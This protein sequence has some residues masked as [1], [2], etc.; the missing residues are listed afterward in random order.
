M[1]PYAFPGQHEHSSTAVSRYPWMSILLSLLVLYSSLLPSTPI[2]SL[3]NIFSTVKHFIPKCAW[4][5]LFIIQHFFEIFPYFWSL[6]YLPFT[7][8]IFWGSFVH[9]RN[10][11]CIIMCSTVLSCVYISPLQVTSLWELLPPWGQWSIW[12]ILMSS[13]NTVRLETKC[14][15]KCVLCQQ[16]IISEDGCQ[17][18]ATL[19]YKLPYLV[20]KRQVFKIIWCTPFL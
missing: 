15:H 4:I 13:A 10:V 2:H 1:F 19:W 3:H 9:C 6:L 17:G 16:C 8:L 7:G 20:A 12:L 14:L 5:S 11:H 18:K